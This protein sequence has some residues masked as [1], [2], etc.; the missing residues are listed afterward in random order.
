MSNRHLPRT[1]T[2]RAEFDGGGGLAADLYPT[3][4]RPYLTAHLDDGIMEAVT[5]NWGND[6]LAIEM[7]GPGLAGN[8]NSGLGPVQYLP[9]SPQ[10]HFT[11]G[12]LSI[13]STTP[14]TPAGYITDL[15]GIVRGRTQIWLNWTPVPGSKGT[16]IY[17]SRLTG[18]PPYFENWQAARVGYPGG[19]FKDGAIGPLDAGREYIYRAVPYYDWG[20]GVPL[21]MVRCRPHRR[22]RQRHR[23]RPMRA[24]PHGLRLLPPR[25]AP[26]VRRVRFLST[27]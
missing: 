4:P 23:C 6:G 8:M 26:S 1:Y 15:T 17:R 2:L 12:Q 7:L 16:V 21:Q 20:E 25:A 14:I 11:G 27:I 24:L 5:T 9:L 10:F 18:T 22:L 19:F 13:D 3:Y